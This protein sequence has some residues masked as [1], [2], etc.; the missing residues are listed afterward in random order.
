MK[1]YLFFVAIL[2][3]WSCKKDT[4]KTR[5]TTQ[6]LTEFVYTSVTIQPD[7]LYQAYASV[8]GILDQNLVEEGDL[9]TKGQALS[10]IINNTPVLNTQNAKL[11]LDLAKENYNGSAAILSGILDEIE[12]ANL[13]YKNDSVNFFRQQNLWNQNIG[14]KADFDNKQLNYQLSKNSWT[15]LKNKY[16]Q[17]KNQLNTNV[18]QAKNTYQTSLINT[19]DFTVKSTINGKVYA[20]YKAS[21]ELINT[22][23]PIAS[24][25]SASTFIIEMLVDEVDIVKIIKNQDVLIT[26]DA[27]NGKVLEGKVSKIYPKKDERNQTFKVE[28]VFV[29]PPDV[30]YPGLS[31]EANIVISKKQNVLTIP[32][33]YIT[34]NNQVQTDAGLVTITTG[35]GDLESI[36]VLDGITKDTYIYKPE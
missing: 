5:P 22:M 30:L 12:A 8:A 10:Q 13:K 9:V 35:L 31:G 28:A 17:T 6:D 14:S 11:A 19:K 7:S 29:N 25:G 3:L 2:F 36:E 20:L 26:L 18:K 15:L 32:K 33:S 16:N 24:I 27:Y 4:E 21:G 34:G 1:K 23:E